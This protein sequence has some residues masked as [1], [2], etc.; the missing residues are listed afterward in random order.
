MAKGKKFGLTKVSAKSF[1]VEGSADLFVQEAIGPRPGRDVVVFNDFNVFDET[2]MQNPNNQLLVKNL[3]N[4][5]TIGII[6]GEELEE[7]IN[8]K[9]NCKLFCDRSCF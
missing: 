1:D 9:A 2:R 4:F 7:E 8:E 3:I 5:E 6:R